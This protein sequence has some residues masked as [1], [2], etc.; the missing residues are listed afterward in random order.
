MKTFKNRKFYWDSK[1]EWLYM[2]HYKDELL[3]KVRVPEFVGM[4]YN[5]F[6][7]LGWNNN[8]VKNLED[9]NHPMSRKRCTA[10]RLY[11]CYRNRRNQI[12]EYGKNKYTLCS[13]LY[14][15]DDCKEGDKVFFSLNARQEVWIVKKVQGGGYCLVLAS[16]YENYPELVDS[17]KMYKPN[18]F[19]TFFHLNNSSKFS[20]KSHSFEGN[21]DFDFLRKV[22]TL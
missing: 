18:H 11:K 10:Q 20:V 16:A 19:Y 12:W 15:W 14:D 21:I 5:S 3:C 22:K 8:L 6:E 4:I 17:Y 1:G 7:V 9:H 13:R 2:I